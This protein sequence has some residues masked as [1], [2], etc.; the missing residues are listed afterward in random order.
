MNTLPP[1]SANRI[2]I[3]DDAVNRVPSAGT[4]AYAQQQP[5]LE[6]QGLSIYDSQEKEFEE[7][8]DVRDVRKKQ[9]RCHRS[10]FHTCE[11][12]V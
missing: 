2:Q 7:E 8:E 9:V 6:K 10:L 3:A 4:G 11:A 12:G 1:M 5:R